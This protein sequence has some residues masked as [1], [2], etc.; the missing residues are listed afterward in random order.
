MAD[1]ILNGNQA[2]QDFTSGIGRGVLEPDIG[3]FSFDA[4]EELGSA[5]RPLDIF[6]AIPPPSRSQE[7][8]SFREQITDSEEFNLLSADDLLDVYGESLTQEDFNDPKIMDI[9]ANESFQIRRE[10]EIPPINAQEMVD[11]AQSINI[12]PNIFE[13]QNNEEIEKYSSPKLL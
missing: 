4:P 10:K 5:I 11:L 12:F 13:G 1:E 6:G 8:L 2:Q 9:F 7:L 3:D